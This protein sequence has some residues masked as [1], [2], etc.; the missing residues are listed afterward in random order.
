MSKHGTSVVRL[1]NEELSMDIAP[2]TGGRII[3]LKH[4]S[5]GREFL[6][7]KH[8]LTLERRPAGSN[9][10]QN[11]YGG[12]DEIIPN[13]LPENIHGIAC[14]D[15]G[16]LWTLPLDCKVKNETFTLS[17]LLP[18]FGLHYTRRMRLKK[19]HL[20]CDYN[21]T[22]RARSE[23]KFIWKMHAALA[24]QPG[25]NII[26]P[27]M[28]ACVADHNWSRSKLT[29]P[30]TWA[31]DM[32]IIPESDESTEFLRLYDLTE[33]KMGLAARDGAAI[34]VFFDL[35]IFHYCYYFAS[36]GGMGGAFFGVLEPNA[37]L[38][39]QPEETIT[40]SLVWTIN[41]GD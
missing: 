8:G 28:T 36:Y 32:A 7:K 4:R 16:E 34:T 13:D 35:N 2:D 21:I 37:D 23:R 39:L 12:I 25:D 31:K 33:G 10:D 3:S 26:C 30:F 22:N 29:R 24:I 9:Y 27:A 1:E 38:K 14:P 17:G 20:V 40:T 19:N 18:G 15:H 41:K 5:S 6:W 11:F